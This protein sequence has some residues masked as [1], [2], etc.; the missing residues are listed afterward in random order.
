MST[1]LPKRSEQPPESTWDVASIFP[2]EPSWEAAAAELEALIPRLESY[3]GRRGESAAVLLEWLELEERMLV[4][5]GRVITYAQML[6]DADTTDPVHAAR[7]ERTLALAT[8]VGA[9]TAG[10]A[11]EIA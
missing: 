5:S 7:W 2:D 11:T 3:R 6:H 10:A 9:A 4:D 8:R 1:L